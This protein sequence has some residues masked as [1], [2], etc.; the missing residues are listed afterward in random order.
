M[1]MEVSDFMINDRTGSKSISR[2]RK[3]LCDKNHTP[4]SFFSGIL[5]L[6]IFA[7]KRLLSNFFV[8]LSVLLFSWG[9]FGHAYAMG[10]PSSSHDHDSK[11]SCQ[12]SS[13][14]VL[15]AHH[16]EAG[17]ILQENLG[18]ITVQTLTL[19]RLPQ[20]YEQQAEFPQSVVQDPRNHFHI[21][22]LTVQQRK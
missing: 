6:L 17:I 16:D 9:A 10:W 21:Q 7:M 18:E 8:V 12:E 20:V 1:M 11:P 22:L 13:P 5:C 15:Q 3:T 19:P 14:C 4:E 2:L